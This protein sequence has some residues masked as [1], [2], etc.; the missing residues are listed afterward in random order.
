MRPSTVRIGVIAAII[1]AGLVL[2]GGVVGR[3][4]R[5]T[6]A[7]AQAEVPAT[8]ADRLE[9][10]ITR[11]QDRLRE[12]PGDWRTWASLGLAYLERARVTT[13]PVWYVKAEEAVRQSL[14]VHPKENTEA[15]T[16]RGALANAR[17]DFAAAR[18]DALAV[19]GSNAYHADAYAVLAD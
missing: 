16:A 14:R 6:P 15:L 4:P 10:S 8:S 9:Q 7:S 2:V 17:H 11:A 13:D 19:V 5:Q 1:A 18:R 3:G 12:V